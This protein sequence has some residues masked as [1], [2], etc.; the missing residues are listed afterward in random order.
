MSPILQMAA[1]VILMQAHTLL[2]GRVLGANEPLQ[3][4]Y[5]HESNGCTIRHFL[6]LQHD[7]ICSL[8]TN[9]HIA[10]KAVAAVSSSL[11][12]VAA[13]SR[14]ASALIEGPAISWTASPAAWLT[15]SPLPAQWSPSRS[16]VG[17]GA[18][19]WILKSGMPQ[20]GLSLLF[21]GTLAPRWVGALPDLLRLPLSCDHA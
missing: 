5:M 6:K 15:L 20:S 10:P 21:V 13:T 9:I 14:L 2:S 4:E 17:G 18:A 19:P 16:L 1:A 11:F 12:D 7:I 3:T 8:C